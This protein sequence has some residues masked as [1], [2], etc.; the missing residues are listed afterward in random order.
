MIEWM[1]QDRSAYNKTE[2]TAEEYL[3]GREVKESELQQTGK[4]KTD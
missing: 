1:Y 3:L 2:Q 4:S